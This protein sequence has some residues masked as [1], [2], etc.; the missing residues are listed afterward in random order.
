MPGAVVATGVISS[1]LNPD[2]VGLSPIE[3]LDKIVAYS[4][5]IGLYIILDRHSG[6]EGDSSAEPLWYIP[7]DPY[8]TE[9]RFIE[10]WVMLAER[11]RGTAVIGA[12]LMNEPHTNNVLNATWGTGNTSTDW[13]LAAQ[14]AGN[15]IL[16][17][18]PDW[19][20]IVEGVWQ[21]TWWG[22]NLKGV[23]EFPVVLNVPNKLVYSAH[24]YSQDIF[25]HTWLN[26][27]DFP[28]NMPPRWDSF[29]GYIYKSGIAP[30]LLG[31]FGTDFAYPRDPT[32]LHALVEYIDTT[33]N[34][35]QQGISWT[36]WCL[37]P[38]SGGTNGILLDDWQTVDSYKFSFLNHSLAPTAAPTFSPSTTIPTSAPTSWP[39]YALT[40]GPSVR[41]SS[42][43]TYS[44]SSL[45]PT[46]RPSSIAPTYKVTRQPT[47]PTLAPTKV[48]T[49]S[50]TFSYIPTAAPSQSPTVRPTR[51]PTVPTKKPTYLPTP[52]PTSTP[53]NK[54]TRLPSIRSTRS[55]RA[56]PTRNP[57]P[58]P[59]YTT[60]LIPSHHGALSTS[61]NQIVDLNGNPVRLTGINW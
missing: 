29:W 48:P 7:G 43:P 13:N 34:N 24:E 11:Y 20:I 2:L 27:Q 40:S 60:T 12:D 36:F 26:A 56:R 52:S 61:G 25:N 5:Q 41:P 3:T 39:T 1:L 57:T 58:T 17:V 22:G 37:N 35:A 6:K 49:N 31:E 55:P 59:T 16:A 18:N 50:P 15:A 4:G 23:A 44:P 42:T 54:P 14:R 8:Y 21:D 32:W 33:V 51:S 47:L 30:V 10:D 9:A 38:I 53:T 28:S 45:I 46:F 19:L